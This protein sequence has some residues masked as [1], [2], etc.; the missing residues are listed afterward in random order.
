MMLSINKSSFDIQNEYKFIINEIL[1]YYENIFEKETGTWQKNS[2]IKDQIKLNGAMKF[3]SGIQW[4]NKMEIPNKKLIDFALSI[5]IELDGCNFTNSLFAIYF[6]SKGINK[7][8]K[9]EIINRCILCLNYVL[10][11][12]IPGSGFSFHYNSCQTRYYTQKVSHGFKQADL[13]GTAMFL[14]GINLALT[15]MRGH[16]PKG[17]EHWRLFK[18]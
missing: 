7:Y 13:H 14:L 8:R 1:K 17:S 5:P 6:A 2:N 3:Y 15:L 11:H 4:V 16:E 18:T 12:K 9:D 10:N